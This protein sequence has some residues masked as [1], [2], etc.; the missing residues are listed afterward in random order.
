MPKTL[1]KVIHQIS[2]T[3][4]CKIEDIFI[5]FSVIFGRYLNDILLLDELMQNDIYVNGNFGKNW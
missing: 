3:I 4:R 2:P 5:I 1:E